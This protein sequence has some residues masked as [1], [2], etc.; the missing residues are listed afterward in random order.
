[1]EAKTM[2]QF[3]NRLDRHWENHPMKYDYGLTTGR[4][5]AVRNDEELPIE[6][7]QELQAEST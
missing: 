6:S 4:L 5:G 2:F 3:E 1:V 7:R